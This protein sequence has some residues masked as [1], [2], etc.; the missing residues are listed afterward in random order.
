VCVLGL[1]AEGYI[2]V[3]GPQS[4]FGLCVQHLQN[5]PPGTDVQRILDRAQELRA[6]LVA[7]Y[8]ESI[9][10]TT[11]AE[12]VAQPSVSTE[13][14]AALLAAF[15]GEP[16][17]GDEAEVAVA[18]QPQPQENELRVEASGPLEPTLAAGAESTPSLLSASTLVVTDASSTSTDAIA[19]VLASAA[20]ASTVA[21][22]TRSNTSDADLAVRSFASSD[23][24]F[25]SATT[26][27]ASARMPAALLA[28]TSALFAAV[29]IPAALSQDSQS[30]SSWFERLGMGDDHLFAKSPQSNSPSFSFR[31][32][33]SPE[34]VTEATVSAQRAPQPISQPEQTHDPSTLTA[35]LPTSPSL[36]ALLDSVK[37]RWSSLFDTDI[38]PSAILIPP[39]STETDGT[40][41]AAAP[42]AD[43]TVVAGDNAP[44]ALAELNPLGVSANTNM[45]VC[46][47]LPASKTTPA[48]MTR[49]RAFF[50]SLFDDN[51]EENRV[52]RPAAE[53]DA[54]VVPTTTP[55]TTPKLSR[56]FGAMLNELW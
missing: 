7:H 19:P 9:P 25:A 34:P 5:Y 51:D 40:A 48:A 36:P 14:M 35:S 47:A 21:Q 49:A 54:R 1:G 4:E 15:Y 38:T 2:C 43:P 28:S 26:T 22:P 52:P 13:T 37:E 16:T 45:A 50:T 6:R 8:L 24:M 31:F 10:T 18:Q 29:A 17:E 32:L 42:P 39:R 41:L 46:D 3:G 12:E 20:S 23:H 11:A 53:Q 30:A 44:L 33:A 27:T 55:M 56:S